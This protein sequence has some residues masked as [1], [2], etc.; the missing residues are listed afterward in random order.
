M[1]PVNVRGSDSHQ[2]AGAEGV[3]LGVPGV[4]SSNKHILPQF[5]SI[6]A[7]PPPAWSNYIGSVKKDSPVVATQLVVPTQLSEVPVNL[8]CVHC[9]HH[10][11]TRTR[12][13]PSPLSWCVCSCLCIF[14]IWP[15]CLLPFCFG[16]LNITE[17]RCSNC[18]KVLGRYKGW[19]GRAD[20]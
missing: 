20:P 3:P 1:P 18:Y 10:V 5:Y 13:H 6:G 14:L 17:H 8:T 9:Q 7:N 2:K 12:T 16:Y 15:C 4:Q 19:K 11:T